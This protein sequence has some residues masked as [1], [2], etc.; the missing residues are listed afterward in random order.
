MSDTEFSIVFCDDVRN[1]IGGRISLMGLF[2]PLVIYERDAP[3]SFTAV[4]FVTAEPDVDLSSRKVALGVALDGAKKP[5]MHPFLALPATR[6]LDKVTQSFI[7]RFGKKPPGGTARLQLIGKIKAKDV[8]FK[9][10]C[11]LTGWVDGR[12]ISRSVLF[13]PAKPSPP[14]IGTNAKPNKGS[15]TK[16]ATRAKKS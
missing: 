2:G 13:N 5:T 8:E 9:E 11:V 3:L 16:K 10:S 7:D 14:R 4:A 6:P 15:A 1:E 12:E